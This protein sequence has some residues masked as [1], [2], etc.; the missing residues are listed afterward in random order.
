M[1]Q[2]GQ[3]IYPSVFFSIVLML[4]IVPATISAVYNYNFIPVC[5]LSLI[6]SAIVYYLFFFRISFLIFAASLISGFSIEYYLYHNIEIFRDVTENIEFYDDA[7]EIKGN[8]RLIKILDGETCRINLSDVIIDRKKI[9][10]NISV[11]VSNIEDMS[12]FRNVSSILFKSVLYPLKRSSRKYDLLSQFE[13]NIIGYAFKNM[14]D[15]KICALKKN[16][17]FSIQYGIFN[18]F[19]KYIPYPFY[20][21]AYSLITG[22]VSGLN[23]YMR[24]SFQ[25]S[26]IIHIIAISGMHLAIIASMLFYVF[27]FFSGETRIYLTLIIIWTFCVF[28]GL[29]P[30]VLRAS[31]M[32]T[33]FFTGKILYRDHSHLNLIAC[34]FMLIMLF[35]PEDVYNAGFQLSFGAVAGLLAANH[36][37]KII[38]NPVFS[39]LIMTL[40]AQIFIIPLVSYHFGIITVAGLFVNLIAIPVFSVLLPLVFIIIV[41]V[42]I[43]PSVSSMAIYP[44]AGLF[45]I[46]C[47][48]SDFM[49]NQF[50]EYNHIQ[51]KMKFSELV[52]YYAILFTVLI[53]CG[54]FKQEKLSSK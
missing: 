24:A 51:Y 46:V 6:I 50:P 43:F 29:T 5:I 44:F 53:F 4:C 42:F 2:N 17:F 28:A 32:L 41:I 13:Q 7:H 10:Y 20:Y 49:I 22:D 35:S 19:Q 16:I 11:K 39:L 45:K 14:S 37:F 36:F 1:K 8:V 38:K 34:S 54:I 9:K 25:N 15:I 52:I 18:L 3:R 30:A 40:Y 48:S 26:G 23:M 47:K 21:P 12:K 31:V 33:L 27:S